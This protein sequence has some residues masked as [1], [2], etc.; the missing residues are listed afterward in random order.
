MLRRRLPY[1]VAF[2]AVTLLALWVLDDGSLF[3]AFSSAS[4]KGVH[5][6]TFQTGGG[7]APSR[8]E[9]GSGGEVTAAVAAVA[10]GGG[11]DCSLGG[12]GAAC[13]M[14]GGAAASAFAANASPADFEAGRRE[15]P[16]LPMHKHLTNM[17]PDPQRLARLMAARRKQELSLACTCVKA[18]L[19]KGR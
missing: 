8:A 6:E 1:V 3:S 18:P 15:N 16:R 7:A 14:P 17:P 12:D 4:A 13:S 9:P 19:L 10:A 11:G 2:A 5:N